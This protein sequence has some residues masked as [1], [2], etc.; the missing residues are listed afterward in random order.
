MAEGIVWNVTD[1]DA[2]N[3]LLWPGAYRFDHQGDILVCSQTHKQRKTI[4]NEEQD[5]Q[6]SIQLL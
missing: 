6:G 5:I 1:A 2:T 4:M 3:L